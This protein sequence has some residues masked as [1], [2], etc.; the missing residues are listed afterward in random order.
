MERVLT[1]LLIL[2][3]LTTLVANLP[4][5]WPRRY[6]RRAGSLVPSFRFF[7]PNPRMR[8]VR[9][10]TVGDDQG[11]DGATS[12]WQPFEFVPARG[13]VA[14]LWNPERRGAMAFERW[15]LSTCDAIRSADPLARSEAV[16]AFARIAGVVNKRLASSPGRA[17]RMRIA[18]V[19]VCPDGAESV[20]CEVWSGF[21]RRL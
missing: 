14:T 7:A 2:W 1:G 3:F 18:V 13:A 10:W 15:C 21:Q 5:R 8:Q 6:V 19:T 20:S 9:V 4:W 12:R 11:E 17:F 16:V